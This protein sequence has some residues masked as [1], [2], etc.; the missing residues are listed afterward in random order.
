MI[1]GWIA[2]K[3]A[4]LREKIMRNRELEHDPILFKWI[5]LPLTPGR[6]RPGAMAVR[7]A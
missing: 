2:Q 5:M 6:F 4:G 1:K 3:F 7:S